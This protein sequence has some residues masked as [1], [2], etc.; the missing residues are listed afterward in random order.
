MQVLKQRGV[1]LI[2]SLVA[3][4]VMALGVLGILGVQMRTLADTQTSVR[5][6]QAVRL[7]EDLSERIR[8][9]P[10]GL[11]LLASYAIDTPEPA[12]TPGATELAA[13]RTLQASCTTSA[14]SG[15]QLISRDRALWLATVQQTLPLG[16]ARVFL[17]ASEDTPVD[18]RQLG[19]MISW[20]ENERTAAAGLQP[21]ATSSGGV[22]CP[23]ERSCHVQYI[24]PGARCLPYGATGSTQV[25]CP[26]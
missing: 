9:N 17:V 7:I 20:R 23:A 14:C 2:E 1:T 6:A 13:L 10:N 5:R 3:I 4:V 11:S 24:Q 8:V 26:D 22:S 19:V 16:H 12:A 18:R 25:I 21:P 15:A